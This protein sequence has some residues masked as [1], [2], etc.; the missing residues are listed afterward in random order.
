MQ[1]P[2]T[3]EHVEP[4]LRLLDNAER[5]LK[6]E[7]SWG[8]RYYAGTIE[9]GACGRVWGKVVECIPGLRHDAETGRFSWEE[10]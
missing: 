5:P 1:T 10:E 7:G 6:T 9:C 3:C 2:T 4:P 8:I